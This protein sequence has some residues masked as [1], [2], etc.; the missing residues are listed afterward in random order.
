MELHPGIEAVSQSK[1][2]DFS[3][4]GRGGRVGG[5]PGSGMSMDNET[6][7]KDFER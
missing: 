4:R 1:N 3:D 7:P 5:L 2:T 6:L